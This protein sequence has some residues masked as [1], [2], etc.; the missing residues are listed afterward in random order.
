MPV[1]QLAE[2]L[3]RSSGRLPSS[4]D[5]LTDA[6]AAPDVERK[7][8][9]EA[10][11]MRMVKGFTGQ[12]SSSRILDFTLLTLLFYAYHCIYSNLTTINTMRSL[13]STRQSSPTISAPFHSRRDST[14]QNRRSR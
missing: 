14:R 12:V 6:E 5:G 11:L 4:G 8:D 7:E 9:R 13:D 2:M 3:R 10:L 1:A